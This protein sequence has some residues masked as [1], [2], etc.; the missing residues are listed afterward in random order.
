M[1]DAPHIFPGPQAAFLRAL[2][3]GRYRGSVLSRR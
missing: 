1:A 2:A 3:D